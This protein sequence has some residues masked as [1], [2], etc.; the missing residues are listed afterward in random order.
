MLFGKYR[1]IRKLATGGMA[2]IFLARQ[3][4]ME[5]FRKDVVIKRI[6][7]IHA[8]NDELIEMFIDEARIA[9]SLNHPN[10]VQIYELGKFEDDHFIAMEYVHGQDLRRTAERGLA[11]GNYIPLR[12]A[13]RGIADA[14][15]GL[16]YAHT[17]VD[18]SGDAL[19]IVHRDISPQNILVSFDG[20][21]KILDFGI[22]KAEN[23]I[24]DNRTGQLKGKYAYMSPEQ[25]NG[26]D[27]DARSDIFSLGIVLYEIT[28]CRR[29]FKGDTDIQTIKR[30]S[31][32][33]V[34][35]P[36][37]IQ[38]EFPKRLEEIILKALAKEPD[39]R[40]PS[41]RELQMDLEDFLSDNRMKTGPVQIGE[42]MRE[43]FPDKLER[44]GEDPTF[45]A[46]FR[47]S[48][49]KK[50]IEPT[51]PP[52]EPIGA[53][54]SGHVPGGAPGRPPSGGGAPERPPG[55]GPPGRPPGPLPPHLRGGGPPGRPPGG[56]PGR[57]PGG[58]PPGGGRPPNAAGKHGAGSDAGVVSYAANPDAPY[59][60][61]NVVEHKPKRRRISSSSSDRSSV[62]GAEYQLVSED[63][64]EIASYERGSRLYY[65]I[66]AAVLLPMLVYAGYL[67]VQQ[68][69]L[70]ASSDLL[71]VEM[72]GDPDVAVEPPPPPLPHVLVNID[73]KPPGA[74]VV[75]NG[76]L[77]LGETPGD[78]NVVPGRDGEQ[79]QLNTIS[80]YLKGY[81]PVHKT[82]PIP[83]HGKPEDISLTLEKLK[84]LETE[85]PKVKPGKRQPK[86]PPAED[87]PSDAPPYAVG[88]ISV[89]TVP[90]GVEVI[91]DGRPVGASPVIIENVAGF[92]EHHITLRK[93]GFHD[94]VITQV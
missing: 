90:E 3:E 42:Y 87:K 37:E 47:T 20:V 71:N 69:G 10:I 92:V 2:E 38:P 85:T 12:H 86:K 5:G 75:V 43:I 14:A 36:T 76:I 54:P 30:V 84:P 26:L 13:V 40:Y 62:K 23:K 61:D 48:R 91:L 72:D 34:T 16:H 29:L 55:G 15:A 7:P 35:P 18:D 21:L 66:L 33:E 45:V 11:V 56:P 49:P 82:V 24:V 78:F 4:G 17:Q 77:Q 70:F 32:A 79:K 60:I 39:D 83:A 93:K 44:P 50:P 80:L 64:S 27:V 57:P 28:L 65:Y 73:S 9:A 53:P 59:A 46:S 81:A 58:G 67:I 1:L 74:S 94:H 41:A 88:K 22:A 63:E 25:C 8:D 52:P 51:P 31:D 6:L 68:G 89:T 19:N